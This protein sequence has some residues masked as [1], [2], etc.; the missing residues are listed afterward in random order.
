[1]IDMTFSSMA[2]LLYQ[3]N[4]KVDMLI[5]RGTPDQ[6]SAVATEPEFMTLP[7]AAEF[8]NRSLS[9]LYGLV[10]RKEIPHLKNGKRLAFK[11]SEL[12]EWLE[13]G[14]RKT[15]AQELAD[16]EHQMISLNKRK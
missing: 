5:D 8:L 13:S 11:R 10:N 16:V 3:L 1:M 9:T 2:E 7:Q 4:A 12:I 6:R 15:N 14:R